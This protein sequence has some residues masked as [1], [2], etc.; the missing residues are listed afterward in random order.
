MLQNERVI[1]PLIKACNRSFVFTANHEVSLSVLAVIAHRGMLPDD[2]L[3]IV[4]KISK[5]SSGVVQS[6]AFEV[7]AAVSDPA[8]VGFLAGGKKQQPTQTAEIKFI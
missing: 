4:K 7:I 8:Y 6:A 5:T 3:K 1:V 2:I